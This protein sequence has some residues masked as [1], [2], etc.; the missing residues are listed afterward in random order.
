MTKLENVLSTAKADTTGGRD[1]GASRTD[2]G[3][4]RGLR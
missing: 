3:Q 2:D 1:G 4:L